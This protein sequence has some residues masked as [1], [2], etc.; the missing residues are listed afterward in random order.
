MT[1]WTT[2]RVR[3]TAKDAAAERKPDD[4]TWSEYIAAERYDPEIADAVDYAEI[5]KQTADEVE[6]RLR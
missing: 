4:M 3:Q 2:I 5:A 6:R 1:K